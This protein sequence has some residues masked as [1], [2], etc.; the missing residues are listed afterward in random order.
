MNHQFP[1]I[2]VAY[3]ARGAGKNWLASFEQFLRSYQNNNAGVDHSLYII[4]KGFSDD[5]TLKEAK[6]L[7]STVPYTPIH[8]GDDNLDIGAYID[9]ANQINEKT[10]CVFNTHSEILTDNWLLKLAVNLA[11][12]NVGLV[13]A[14]ASYESLSELNRAFPKFP[15]IHVRSN[16]FMINRE[17]FCQITKDMIIAGKHEAFH[18]ESGPESMTRQVLATGQEALLVGSNGRGYSPKYWPESCTFRLGNQT[19]LLVGDNQT[20]NFNNF[21]WQEKREFV[22]R[23]WGPYIQEDELLSD[24]LINK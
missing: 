15:N 2:A 9:W 20:R 6:K 3:L 22:L 18:F 17:L 8:L 16:A 7:F 11:I 21:I 23:S 5:S 12:P 1:S 24:R 19:N 13:G 14:T 4:F 10:I